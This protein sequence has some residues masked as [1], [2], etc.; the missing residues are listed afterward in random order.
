[1]DIVLQQSRNLC[2]TDCI[3]N[4]LQGGTASQHSPAKEQNIT[5]TAS[6]GAVVAKVQLWMSLMLQH[7]DSYLTPRRGCAAM[8]S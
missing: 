5:L 3:N 2:H 6:K 4:A 1:M 8:M 7:L